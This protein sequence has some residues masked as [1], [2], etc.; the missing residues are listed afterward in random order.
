M[1]RSNIAVALTALI[2]V[3]LAVLLLSLHYSRPGSMLNGWARA[4]GFTILSQENCWLFKGPFF[5]T[6]SKGQE[7]YRVTV[8]DSEGRVRSG[9]VRCGGFWLGLLSDHVEARW[10][11]ER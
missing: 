2:V 5:W 8:R 9:F 1:D 10:D 11:D 4:N 6:S 3:A 7:V